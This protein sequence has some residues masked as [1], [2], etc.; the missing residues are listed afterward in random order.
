[1]KEY[2]KTQYLFF[3]IA[4]VNANLVLAYTF[5]YNSED[6]QNQKDWI[7]EIVIGLIAYTAILFFLLSCGRFSKECDN[8]LREYF[9][10]GDLGKSTKAV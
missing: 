4:L 3:E 7:M 9:S 10:K 1:M 5:L 2:C 8:S 6:V